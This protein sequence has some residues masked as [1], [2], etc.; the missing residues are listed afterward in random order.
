MRKTLRITMIYIP[1]AAGKL[2]KI[3][4][5][6]LSVTQSEIQFGRGE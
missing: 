4:M 6:K 3:D 5:V 1:W 2:A